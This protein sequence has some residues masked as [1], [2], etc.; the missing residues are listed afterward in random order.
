MPVIIRKE[1]ME[2][3]DLLGLEG[4][5]VDH[6]RKF[7]H[8]HIESIGNDNLRQFVRLGIQHAAGVGWKKRGP[9]EF[10][11]EVMVMLGSKFHTDPQYP[12]AAASLI[13]RTEEMA[14]ADRLH[15]EVMKYYDAVFGPGLCYE[16]EAI[17]RVLASEYGKDRQL[18][19]MSEPEILRLLEWAF[20]QKYVF[21]GSAAIGALIKEAKHLCAQ[22]GVAP[23]GLALVTVTLFTFGHGCFSDPQYPWIA[24]CMRIK[25]PPKEVLLHRMFKKYLKEA[26][27]NMEKG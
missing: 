19:G 20:P 4:H 22:F 17:Q 24:E 3:F 2:A 26:L 13:R 12:W 27:T 9:A 18:S 1:Q 10:F 5:L 25:E 11:L 16:V 23:T 21:V 7:A 15:N 14:N 8:D 6:L